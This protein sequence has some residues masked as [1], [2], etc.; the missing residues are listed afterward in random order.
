MKNSLRFLAAAL[1]L[2]ACVSAAAP[3]PP[4]S[5]TLSQEGPS[6]V[7]LCDPQN[8]KCQMPAAPGSSSQR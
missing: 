8:P 6:P 7:P 2:A 1:L 4:I 3:A 5:T